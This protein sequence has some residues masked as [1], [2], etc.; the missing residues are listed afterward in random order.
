M[1]NETATER[2]VSVRLSAE[3]SRRLS[4]MA[5]SE[6]R[7]VSY[8]IRRAIQR[9]IQPAPPSTGASLPAASVEGSSNHVTR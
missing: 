2:W 5:D 1:V 4:E 6:D 3:M 9:E 8:V 7:T